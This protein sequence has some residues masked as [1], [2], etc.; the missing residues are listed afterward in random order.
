MLS[1]VSEMLLTALCL[2][3]E[4]AQGEPMAASCDSISF[5]HAQ[6]ACRWELSQTFDPHSS[7][8]SFHWTKKRP[9]TI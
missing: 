9:S 7:Q 4:E 2:R 6:P 1:K 3:E 8:T 5:K